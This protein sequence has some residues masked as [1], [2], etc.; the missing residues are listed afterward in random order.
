MAC[1]LYCCL[2]P[3]CEALR[4][5]RSGFPIATA[6]PL[7]T[8]CKGRYTLWS[9]LPG[10]SSPN[11]A[12]LDHSG[13]RTTIENF[14][15]RIQMCLQRRGA[16]LE[17]IFWAPV[18][19]RVFVV[20]TWN[21]EMSATQAWP[22]VAEVLCQSKCNFGSYSIFGDDRFFCVTLYIYTYIYI[23]MYTSTTFPTE[24][25]KPGILINDLS[26]NLPAF[27]Y[28]KCWPLQKCKSWAYQSWLFQ[29]GPKIFCN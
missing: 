16:H 15:R 18:T 17:H 24:K 1:E 2:L 29:V 5:C 4:T 19:E 22:N 8:V 10:L 21:L 25:L 20:Q 26:D 13:S 3:Q 12:S 11:M 7:S 23:C 27:V 9:A 28:M 6:H 14:A